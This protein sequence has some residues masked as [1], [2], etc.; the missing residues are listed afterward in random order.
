MGSRAKSVLQKVEARAAPQLS[1][2]RERTRAA[3]ARIGAKVE[4]SSAKLRTIKVSSRWP[5]RGS[6]WK[7]PREGA[8]AAQQSP[9]DGKSPRDDHL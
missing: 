6:Q 2:I 8:P 5:M 3:A 1:A 4:G 7:S 9:R